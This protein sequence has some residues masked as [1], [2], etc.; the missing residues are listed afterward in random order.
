MKKIF[1]TIL[2]SVLV[3]GVSTAVVLASG[4]KVRGEKAEG[5][6]YQEC[7]ENDGECPFIG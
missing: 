3:L 7:V 2:L 4:G 5:P 6:A 1:L